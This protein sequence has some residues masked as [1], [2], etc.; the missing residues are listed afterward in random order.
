MNI[1]LSAGD[2]GLLE[3]LGGLNPFF[4][5]VKH[6][7]PNSEVFFQKI[8]NVVRLSKLSSS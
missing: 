1:R 3:I 2:S 5:E 7:L 4:C 8:H 6:Q